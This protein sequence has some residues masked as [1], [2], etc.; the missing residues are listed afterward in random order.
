MKKKRS[1]Y[2]ITAVA[3]WLGCLGFIGFGTILFGGTQQVEL[4]KAGRNLQESQD[5]L[6]FAQS[7]GKEETKR[8]TQERL[9]K[10][11]QS[12]N[13]FSCPASGESSLV[14]QISQL[15]DSIGLKKFTSR[16]PEVIQE[17][18]LQESKHIAEGWLTTEFDADYLKTAAFINSLER[19]EPV[20]FVESIHLRSS[21]DN[22]GEASVRLT[23]SYLIRKP[24]ES[25]AATKAKTKN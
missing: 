15:A 5:K 19:H 3:V 4:E 13:T 8:R 25:C 14:F 10:T 18:T 20:L 7:A 21:R 24:D 1:I 16:F 9:D 23:L 11:Q 2:K 6:A 22:P 17:T 12:L